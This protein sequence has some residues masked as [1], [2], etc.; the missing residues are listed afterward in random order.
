M[1]CPFPNPEI[2]TIL[3]K[4]DTYVAN[5]IEFYWGENIAQKSGKMKIRYITISVEKMAP[6]GTAVAEI[7]L[8]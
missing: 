8:I 4:N 6:G 1:Q 7:F 2:F 3:S 5:A